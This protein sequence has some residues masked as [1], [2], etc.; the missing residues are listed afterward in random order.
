ML[1]L[2]YQPDFA[3]LHI[4]TELEK[5]KWSIPYDGSKTPDSMEYCS[6]CAREFKLIVKDFY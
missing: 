3:R 5:I 1:A 2:F 6:I 4:F